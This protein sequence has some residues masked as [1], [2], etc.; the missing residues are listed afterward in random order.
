MIEYPTMPVKI[1]RLC[2]IKDD[3]QRPLFQAPTGDMVNH[4]F[5]LKRDVYFIAHTASRWEKCMH[6][7]KTVC[8]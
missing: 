7:P 6:V 2:K 5:D 4:V 3:T 1:Y 8:H